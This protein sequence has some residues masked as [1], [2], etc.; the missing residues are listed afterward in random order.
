M[1]GA[2]DKS[3]GLLFVTHDLDHSIRLTLQRMQQEFEGLDENRL[4]NTP[5]ED[6]KRYLV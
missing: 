1:F 4:L 6:L 5:P 3:Q 2:I